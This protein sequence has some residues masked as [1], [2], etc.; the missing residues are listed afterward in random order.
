MHTPVTLKAFGVS[1][2]E[3][4]AYQFAVNTALQTV[5][6]AALPQLLWLNSV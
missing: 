6:I 4:V 1:P 2:V 3:L 5:A